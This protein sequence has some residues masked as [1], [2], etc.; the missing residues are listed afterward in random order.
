MRRALPSAA[1]LLSL[2]GGCGSGPQGPGAVRGPAL[3][4]IPPGGAAPGGGAVVVRAEIS[5]TPA[6]RARGLMERGPLPADS[7]MLFV[8]PE[9]RPLTF[10]MKDCPLPLSAAFLDA[11][12]RILAIEEMAPGAGV[13][14]EN[15]PRYGPA[16]PARF[17]LEMEA[18]W[19]ARKGIG[20]GDTADLSAA[21][22]GVVPR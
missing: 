20:P 10:W 14:D 13:P 19:F 5:S 21:I 8:Y 16:Q 2:L 18:G 7:G 12:G 17:V 15:L 3:V 11:S 4:V 1:L 22:R 6:A 9:D